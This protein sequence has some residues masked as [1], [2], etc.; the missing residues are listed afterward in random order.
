MENQGIG[1]VT[2]IR[3]ILAS[4]KQGS[5]NHLKDSVTPRN[6]PPRRAGGSR[7]KLDRFRKALADIEAGRT[8]NKFAMLNAMQDTIKKKLSRTAWS[9]FDSVQGYAKP[10]GKGSWFAWPAIATI[11]EQ[12]G[13]SERTAARARKECEDAGVLIVVPGGGRSSNTYLINDRPWIEQA[14]RELAVRIDDDGTPDTDA[15]NDDATTPELSP[16]PSQSCHRI[17]DENGG[18]PLTPMAEEQTHRTKPNRTR[19]SNTTTAHDRA[20]ARREARHARMNWDTHGTGTAD[21][22]PGGGGGGDVLLAL[23]EEGINEPKRSRIAAD[24]R[25]TVEVIREIVSKKRATGGHEGVIILALQDEQEI[26]LA[27]NEVADR[28]ARLA[29]ERAEAERAEAERIERQRA[30][31]ERK[32]ELDERNRG[33][34][35]KWPPEYT[36]QLRVRSLENA[37]AH[38]AEQLRNVGIDDTTELGN[39][40]RAYIVGRYAKD[41]AEPLLN[42]THAELIEV[43]QAVSGKTETPPAAMIRTGIQDRSIGLARIVQLGKEAIARTTATTTA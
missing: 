31:A 38:D 40:L 1:P 41:W 30:E 42:L 11:A 15:E 18:A 26:K 5:G 12:M 16:H 22:A 37:N 29:T 27:E 20:A 8:C 13:V 4:R 19:P 23:A 39:R 35:S 32:R 3:P 17:P 10:D 24:P 34:V 7:S 43:Y 21:A 36:E 25:L 6:G 9:F 2:T 28:K 14:E 33:W